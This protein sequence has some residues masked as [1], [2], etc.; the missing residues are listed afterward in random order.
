[1]EKAKMDTKQ[2]TTI[3]EQFIRKSDPDDDGIA[4]KQITDHKTVIVE[5]SGDSG[6]AVLM[7]E[8]LVDGKKYRAGYSSRS[9]VVYISQTS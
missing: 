9:Q 2:M 7:S 8:Y 4:V 1:M 3:I 6:Q 5:R